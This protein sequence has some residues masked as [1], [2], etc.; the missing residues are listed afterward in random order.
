MLSGGIGVFVCMILNEYNKPR[1]LKVARAILAYMALSQE[2]TGRLIELLAKMERPYS[3]EL[4]Q[5]LCASVIMSPIEVVPLTREGKVLLIQRPPDDPKFANLWHSPGSLQL[6]GDTVQ[7]TFNRVIVEELQGV[8]Y[9][10][11]EYIGFEDVMHGTGPKENPRGQER[12]LVFVVWVKEEGYAGPGRFFP[13]NSLPENIITN[14]K[15]LLL[16]L[17]R[18]KYFPTL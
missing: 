14:H 5:A 12:P 16:P 1:P 4:F 18:A 10:A 7:T 17:V 9:S 13:L 15:N 8:E 3:E 6:K 11:P 2:E